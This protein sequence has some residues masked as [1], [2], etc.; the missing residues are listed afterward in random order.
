MTATDAAPLAGTAVLEVT[1]LVKEFPVGAG[2]LRRSKQTVKAV[3]GVSFSVA[4]GETLALGLR[5][6]RFLVDDRD[7]EA[8]VHATTLINWVDYRQGSMGLVPKSRALTSPAI[9][10]ASA[11]STGWKTARAPGAACADSSVAAAPPVSAPRAAMTVVTPARTSAR[12]TSF[13]M[14][15]VPPVMSATSPVRGRGRKC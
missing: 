1:D 12:A 15:W 14:P 2:F 4:R 10:P 7:V 6:H 3:S 8:L 13:P 5:I 9:D 11:R